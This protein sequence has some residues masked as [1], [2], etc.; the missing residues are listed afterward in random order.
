MERS[1][2]DTTKTENNIYQSKNNQPII[3]SPK[4]QNQYDINIAKNICQEIGLDISCISNEHIF[5]ENLQMYIKKKAR[6][7]KSE[8]KVINDIFS[9]IPQSNSILT[10]IIMGSNIIINYSKKDLENL[11]RFMNHLS[12]SLDMAP[13]PQLC[14]ID[15]MVMKYWDLL[16]SNTTT[17]K[18]IKSNVIKLLLNII[19]MNMSEDVFKSINYIYKDIITIE[20]EEEEK[21]LFNFTKQNLELDKKN[22]EEEKLKVILEFS[23]FAMDITEKLK[24][25]DI[26]TSSLIKIIDNADTVFS[27]YNSMNLK[28]QENTNNYIN[29]NMNSNLVAFAHNIIRIY[30]YINF[31]LKDDYFN[32]N[33][34]SFYIKKYIINSNSV[35]L[36]EFYLTNIEKMSQKH[37]DDIDKCLYLLQDFF[38]NENSNRKIH[39]N[40]I[41][42]KAMHVFLKLMDS[43]TQ[44]NKSSD[45][46]KIRIE[47]IIGSFIDMSTTS[48]DIINALNKAAPL[49]DEI[50]ISKIV[51]AIVLKINDQFINQKAFLILEKY[52]INNSRQFSQDQMLYKNIKLA[53]EALINTNH[54]QD[55]FIEQVISCYI[56]SISSSE[57]LYF[58]YNNSNSEIMLLFETNDSINEKLIEAE[59]EDSIK[60]LSCYKQAKSVKFKRC[61]IKYL[62]NSISNKANWES[63]TGT[64]NGKYSLDCIIKQMFIDKNSGNCDYDLNFDITNFMRVFKLKCE[65]MYYSLMEE[66]FCP[67]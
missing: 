39:S 64:T 29:I 41:I 18:L 12:N 32:K 48:T 56:S 53:L 59:I 5:Y 7:G 42:D 23:S 11:E 49:L 16:K 58:M 10:E 63:L 54:N 34:L 57:I 43:I 15:K 14:S 66:V 52:C 35:H 27:F 30:Y 65:K 61:L 50:R 6:L 46:T 36:K 37:I 26:N 9:R 28:S 21:S 44:N 2:V 20:Y 24:N 55:Q 25:M 3:Q 40:E 22:F 60:Y 8:L 47:S 13:D 17:R 67:L 19:L 33:K 31:N 51:C 4:N 38:E 45:T 1:L 62:L